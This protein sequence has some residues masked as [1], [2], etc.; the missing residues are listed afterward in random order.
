[1]LHIQADINEITALTISS[2]KSHLCAGVRG[3]KLCVKLTNLTVA[4]GKSLPRCF[5]MFH[6]KL[7]A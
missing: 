3:R 6:D 2:S 1:M 4:F 7:R 5:I